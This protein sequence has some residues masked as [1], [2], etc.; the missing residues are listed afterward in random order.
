MTSK[1]LTIMF[2]DIKGFTEKTSGSS[3]ENLHQLLESH[4]KLL[5]PVVSRFHG[6]L[7]KTIGDALLISFES[8]T[9][10]I[11]CGI[12]IQETLAGYNTNRLEKDKIFVRVSMS[13]GEVE[14]RDNDVFGE[15]VNLASRLEGITD[16]GEVYFTES[17]Y[18]AMNKSEVPTCEVG[19]RVFKG[20]PEQVKVFR[21]LR[22]IKLTG[23]KDLLQKL[24]I[25]PPKCRSQKWKIAAGVSIIAGIIII[26]LNLLSDTQ[27]DFAARIEKDLAENKLT[28]AFLELDAMGEKYPG[29]PLT[30]EES[31]KCLTAGV[32]HAVSEKSFEEAAR[33][34]KTWKQEVPE[35]NTGSLE[36]YACSAEADFLFQVG[37]HDTALGIYKYLHLQYPDNLELNRH[38][39]QA[40][41]R[42]GAPPEAEKLAGE[43]VFFVAKNSI[44]PDDLGTKRA[45]VS[46][47]ETAEQGRAEEIFFLIRN[48]YPQWM[49][50][51][52]AALIAD[53][54]VFQVRIFRLLKNS[55]DLS[56]TEEVRCRFHQLLTHAPDTAETESALSENLSFFID[57]SGNPGWE[58]VKA[59]AGSAE[60]HTVEIL[61]YLGDLP[62]RAAEFLRV[63]FKAEID[64]SLPEWAVQTK[65]GNLRL[66]AYLMLEAEGDL[67]RIDLWLFHEDSLTRLILADNLQALKVLVPMAVDYFL[68]SPQKKE[69]NEIEE[70][71]L[72]WFDKQVSA[73]K[74]AGDV[75]AFE[76]EELLRELDR[77]HYDNDRIKNRFRTK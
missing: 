10:A 17:V 69:I 34:I 37:R 58:S 51:L 43:A 35:I 24:K 44:A 32:T 74:I 15:A 39:Y 66:N 9:D 70:D 60:I 71:A 67:S 33:L 75:R 46:L 65:S 13:S 68:K 11:L 73:L 47:M 19:F 41:S 56:F 7:I 21:V 61:R 62:A 38:I 63:S 55:G 31:M 16:P 59:E 18:L 20:I 28:E 3:R 54:P 30:F 53:Q 8:P 14:I 76:A 26:A 45:L 22:D 40:C 23:Y 12:M 36:I 27:E 72:I 6:T 52:K 42:T 64:K 49:Q 25:Q 77:L 4:E 2:T 48:K 1:V 57:Q 50:Y 29:D 5:L